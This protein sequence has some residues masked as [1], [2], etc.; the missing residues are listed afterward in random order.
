MNINL[1]FKKF[2]KVTLKSDG[3]KIKFANKR[4]LKR[5]VM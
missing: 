1:G 2:V 3:L 5:Y 4:D